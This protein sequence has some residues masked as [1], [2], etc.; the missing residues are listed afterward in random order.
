MKYSFVEL[1]KFLYLHPLKAGLVVQLVRIRACHAR[2]RGFESRPD[3]IRSSTFE[4]LFFV[5]EHFTYIIYAINF[6]KY[7]KGYSTDPYSRILQNNDLES[8]Y[9]SKFAPWVL[10]YVEKLP[11]K[12]EAL[13][14]EKSLKKYDKSQIETLCR[15]PKNILVR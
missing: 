10:I 5:M 1:K 2:G 3:R 8:R 7:Y 13:I 9:T 14:R 11:S 6:D 15:S 12:R 4:L